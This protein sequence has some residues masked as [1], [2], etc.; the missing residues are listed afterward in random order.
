MPVPVAPPGQTTD[1]PNSDITGTVTPTTAGAD[2]EVFDRASSAV[3]ATNLT[4]NGWNMA[5]DGL[6]GFNETVPAAASQ[7]GD[8]DGN[9]RYEI[10]FSATFVGS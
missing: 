9:G 1:I 3:I 7:G 5:K 2:W 4:P 8:P 6:G 10:R